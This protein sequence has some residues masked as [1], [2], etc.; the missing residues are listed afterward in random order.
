MWNGY[1]ETAKLGRRTG[2]GITALADT[3]AGL[4]IKYGSD[5]S[6]QEIDKIFQNFAISSMKSSCL[7]AKELGTFPLYDKKL[8]SGHPFLTQLF[9]ED[10][11]LEKIH[12]KYGRRNISLT[13]CAPCGSVSILTQTSSGIEPVFMLEYKRRR[14]IH[15]ADQSK[16]V[17]TDKVGDLWEEYDVNHHG[18]QLWKDITGNTDITLSPYYNVTANDIDLIKGVEIQAIIQKWLT[19]SVSKTANCPKNT[20]KDKISELFLLAYKLG[21]KGFTIYREGSRDG[22]LIA[23]EDRERFPMERPKELPCDVHHITAKG[24][25]F[26][27]LVGLYDGRPYEIFSG[28]NNILNP[29]IKSGTIVKKKKNFYK[30]KFDNDD[31]LSPIT[32]AMTE[33]QESISRLCSLL[34]RNEV[35]IHDIICQL[36]RIG[37]SRS[38]IQCFSSCLARALKKYIKNGTKEEG[39][40]QEC[41]Q[42][43][44]IRQ[45][46]C[47]T[48]SSCGWSKC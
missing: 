28:M 34:L 31:E 16:V 15:G 45:D 14:K 9:S 12:N 8:E 1:L 43:N 27:V 37:E 40:C 46:G 47:I 7:I 30:A 20:T 39:I 22:V 44:L 2:L 13:T 38:D 17:F 26:F 5:Q 11:E 48:C 42:P 23:K 3:L 6:I 4:N 41:G 33:V 24:Q 19:H 32:S 36:E 35:N 10:K 21:C 29:N 18:L 25:K